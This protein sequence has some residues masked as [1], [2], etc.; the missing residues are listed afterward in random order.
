MVELTNLQ[1]LLCIRA[2]NTQMRRLVECLSNLRRYSD[3][4]H[5]EE[6]H[7]ASVDHT[8]V[9]RIDFCEGLVL[10]KEEYAL[11][12]QLRLGAS[13]VSDSSECPECSRLVDC[14]LFYS[15]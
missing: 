2:D 5:L 10:P 8:W 7:D 15:S 13:I 14:K 3:M 11:A 1:K 4:R 9:R 6:L 12:V